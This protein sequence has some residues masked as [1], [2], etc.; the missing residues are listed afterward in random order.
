MKGVEPAL[1]EHAVLREPLVHL[2]ERLRT[3][4]VDPA[5]RVL[6]YV[7]Q[8]GLSQHSQVP[9]HARTGDREHLGE[10]PGAGRMVAQDLQDRAAA[11]VR[12][13]VQHRIHAAN[14]TNWVRTRKGT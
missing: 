12:Q 13:R 1:P 7:D 9:G 4:A 3:E 8:A 6:A 14:V 11:L 5:L 2:H 10:L